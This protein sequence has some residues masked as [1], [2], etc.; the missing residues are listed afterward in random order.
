[1]ISKS[2]ITGNNPRLLPRIKNKQAPQANETNGLF[3]LS[4]LLWWLVLIRSEHHVTAH[5]R[6]NQ[7][8]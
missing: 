1:M 7:S 2:K 3:P 4:N 6:I 5:V 8:L